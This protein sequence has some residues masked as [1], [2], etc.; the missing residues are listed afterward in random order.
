MELR[1]QYGITV[2]AVRRDSQLLFNPEPD[3]E[4]KGNDLLI[5]LGAPE[6][7]AAGGFL[8]AGEEGRA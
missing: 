6:K 3:M 1:K 5:I 8:F 2:L 7:I 4:L